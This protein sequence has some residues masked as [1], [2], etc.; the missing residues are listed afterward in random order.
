MY[1]SVIKNE[2]ALAVPAHPTVVLCF[3]WAV[4]A[5]CVCLFL[6]FDCPLAFLLPFPFSGAILKQAILF[7]LK[8]NRT[9]QILVWRKDIQLQRSRCFKWTNVLLPTPRNLTTNSAIRKRGCV[10]QRVKKKRTIKTETLKS[11]ATRSLNK[12]TCTFV[13]TDVQLTI[14]TKLPLKMWLKWRLP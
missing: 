12:A 13:I 6:L 2:F 3:R 7:W 8:R 9:Q 1:R 14:E 5:S 11:V 4:V 10:C